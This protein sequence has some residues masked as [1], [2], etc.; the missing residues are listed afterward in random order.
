VRAIL[1]LTL[2]AALGAA[3]TPWLAY[4][5]P[6]GGRQGA[7]VA[8]TVAGENLASTYGAVV[9]GGGVSARLA[10]TPSGVETGATKQKKRNQSVMDEIGVIE[11]TIAADAAPGP[12][13]LRLLTAEG[14][15]N[16]RI[17]VIGSAPE[18]AEEPAGRPGK[19]D[20][21]ALQHRPISVPA[22][23][24]TLHGQILPG[25]TD[26]WSLALRGGEP[27]VFAVAARALIP[28]IADAVPGWCQPLLTLR[29]A[30]GREL[31]SADAD[32]FRQ[33]ALLRWTPPADTTC[34]LEL[35]DVLWRGRPD[36]IY[37]IAAG[38]PGP[39]ATTPLPPDGWESLTL[40]AGAVHERLLTGTAGSRLELAVRARRIGSPLDA[41]LELLGPDGAVVAAADDTVDRAQGV[42]TQHADP[43]MIA[44]LPADGAYRLRLSDVLGHGGTGYI[45]QLYA[46]PPRPRCELIAMPS[47][48]ALPA[49]G[50]VPLTVHAVRHGGHS[51][52]IALRLAD[53]DGLILDG[54]LIPAG[55]DRVQ[56]TISCPPGTAPELQ[57]PRV[58]A[59]EGQAA[60]A[61]DAMQA[62][63]WMQLVPCDGATL[64][65]LPGA[66]VRVIPTSAT[67]ALIPGRTARLGLSIERQTGWDGD[68][69]IVLHQPPPG[70]SLRNG[71]IKPGA[72]AGGCEVLLAADAALPAANLVMQATI[73]REDGVRPDGKPKR[74]QATVWLPA[75]RLV[76]GTP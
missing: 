21:A 32:G 48:L 49:G 29:D 55:A 30:S 18:L 50:S 15:S 37:R 20:Q 24:A 14:P 38:P 71:R 34:T 70:V 10:T 53:G 52:A 57:A 73:S 12:R 16:P 28:Y 74:I 75:V 58:V 5:F 44:T 31:A 54:G 46:G 25:E 61:D 62:F 1:A 63:L 65:V 6:A 43:E 40:A 51:G 42:S 39:V 27:V 22:L 11:L 23:P 19:A 66:P 35:R 76:A 69:R 2:G 47:S 4:A 60:W 17:I 9:G 56:A 8:I 72:D 33:D 68:I 13:S 3:D 26:R 67:L 64:A 59:D 36:F 45:A 7:T 41:R